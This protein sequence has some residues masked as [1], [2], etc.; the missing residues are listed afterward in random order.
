[1]TIISFEICHVV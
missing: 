1:M